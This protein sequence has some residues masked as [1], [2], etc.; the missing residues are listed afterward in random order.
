M[1]VELN[2]SLLYYLLSAAVVIVFALPL[3]ACSNN[4]KVINTHAMPGHRV[5]DML[6]NTTAAQG[7]NKKES[8]LTVTKSGVYIY[9]DNSTVNTTG[10]NFQLRDKTDVGPN[11]VR[12]D[13]EHFRTKY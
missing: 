8:P 5:T 9:K 3:C 4:A 2:K 13:A 10:Y 6:K 1:M 11:D 7:L 12:F